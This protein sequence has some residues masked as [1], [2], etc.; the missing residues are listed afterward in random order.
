MSPYTEVS[1]RA[2]KHSLRMR[3][4]FDVIR[5]PDITDALEEH[6]ADFRLNPTKEENLFSAILACCIMR[7]YI[8]ITSQRMIQNL[9][10]SYLI[11][12]FQ[13]R[14]VPPT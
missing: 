12:T 10:N 3:Q 4:F 2:K 9:I 1:R 14:E 7:W 5:P 6:T 11:N 13:K 8:E